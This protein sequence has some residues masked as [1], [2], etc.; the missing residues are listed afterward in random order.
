[1]A[2]SC[3]LTQC[4]PQR[5]DMRRL[6]DDSRAPLHRISVVAPLRASHTDEWLGRT[7]HADAFG[8]GVHHSLAHPPNR[9]RQ[10]WLRGG[11]VEADAVGQATVAVTGGALECVPQGYSLCRQFLIHL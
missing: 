8:D 6:Q 4:L 1:M 11:R 5:R 10:H 9:P 3:G 7:P 2:R